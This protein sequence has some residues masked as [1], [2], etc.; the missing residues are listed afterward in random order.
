MKHFVL[1]T[2]LL[3]PGTAKSEDFRSAPHRERVA[4][5]LADGDFG[6]LADESLETAL[7][8]AVK[9]LREK[10]SLASANWIE[11]G[12]ATY[13]RG[14]LAGVMRDVGDHDPLIEWL[15]L[16]YQVIENDLGVDFCQKSHLR[17]IWLFNFTIPVIFHPHQSEQWCADELMLFPDDTCRQ[18]YR[19]H[20][21]GTIWPLWS[22]MDPYKRAVDHNGFAGAVTYWAVFAACEAATWGTDGTLICGPAG[23]AAEVLMERFAATKISDLVWNKANGG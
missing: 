9:A 14:E 3:M 17:D 6:R 19:R 13:Y 1:A 8:V 11:H 4:I 16:V 15:A 23:G 20:M 12:W 21:A 7:G 10:G 2:L 22:S 18:E 5:R